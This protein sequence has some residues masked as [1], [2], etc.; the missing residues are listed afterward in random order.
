MPGKKL[1]F[2]NLKYS[3]TNEQLQELCAG[4]GEVVNVNIIE[5][6]EIAVDYHCDPSDSRFPTDK[7]LSKS[8]D[9]NGDMLYAHRPQVLWDSIANTIINIAY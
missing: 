7:S 5:G 3:I 6:K 9:K 1:Y 8:P 2:G 4:Y